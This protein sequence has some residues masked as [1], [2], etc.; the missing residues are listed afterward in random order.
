MTPRRSRV[1]VEK[2]VI[3][4]DNPTAFIFIPKP[5]RHFE[6]VGTGSD[7]KGDV[8]DLLLAAIGID[9]A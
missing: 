5:N 2:I 7:H 1:S 9:V 6:S 4:S 8:V 3:A